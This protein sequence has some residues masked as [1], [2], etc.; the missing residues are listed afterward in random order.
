MTPFARWC[1]AHIE[2]EGAQKE[3]VVH[4]SPC[5]VVWDQSQP[6]R[7]DVKLLTL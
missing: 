6:L 5:G 7:Q 4:S 1:L 2:N 3:M